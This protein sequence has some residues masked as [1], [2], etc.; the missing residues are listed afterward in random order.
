MYPDDD[1]MVI[2]VISKPNMN[3]DAEFCQRSPEIPGYLSA[4]TAK[5]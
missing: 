1:G 4:V 3:G 2:S 5:S